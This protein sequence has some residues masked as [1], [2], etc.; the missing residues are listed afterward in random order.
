MRTPN[1]CVRCATLY[2]ITLYNPIA[3]STSAK[4]PNAENIDAPRRQERVCSPRI[5]PSG[6]AVT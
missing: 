5:W 4:S 2:A 6:V 1:S 3:A